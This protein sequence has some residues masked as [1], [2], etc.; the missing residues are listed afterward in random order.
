[1]P[2][3]ILNVLGVENKKVRSQLKNH[4]ENGC[5]KINKVVLIV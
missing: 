3:A 4:V 1:M 5:G 2:K